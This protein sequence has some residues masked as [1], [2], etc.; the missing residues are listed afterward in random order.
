MSG[1]V[2]SDTERA[3]ALAVAV[4]EALEIA[5]IG[6]AI[7]GLDGVVL[8]TNGTLRRWAGT[9]RS[10]PGPA[11][12]LLPAGD[13]RRRLS[14]V[15]A[16][17]A[18]SFETSRCELVP[19]VRGSFSVRLSPLTVAGR[20]VACS[21]FVTD[22]Q[23]PVEAPDRP[24]HE[25]FRDLVDGAADG[26][27]VARGDVL[28]YANRAVRDWLGLPGPEDVV[29]RLLSEI[30]GVESPP[31]TPGQPG[32]IH[33]SHLRR[34]DGGELPVAVSVARVRLPE[35]ATTVL[36]LR[37][38]APPRAESGAFARTLELLEEA[39]GR[40][41][42]TLPAPSP[43]GAG[44]T[45][46]EASER[47]AVAL[48]LCRD[49]RSMASVPIVASAR[50][51]RAEEPA[52]DSR[53]LPRGRA[54]L[55]VVLVCDDEA[56]LAMLTAGLLEQHGYA[57]VT[58][59]TAGSAIEA[60]ATQRIDVMLLDL[61][62]PDGNAHE[63]IARMGEQSLQHPVILT[64]GYAEEDVDPTLLRGPLVVGY[65]AKPYSMD[66]LIAAIDR[67]LEQRTSAGVR[68]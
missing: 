68:A 20:I 4:C 64:S 23:A 15:A 12:G 37:R 28:L 9:D 13:I 61:H 45:S 47:L 40:A 67:A 36:V 49:L 29:G 42:E 38:R 63:V 66:R 8:A 24:M 17:E 18:V 55:G 2:T 33:D 60:L 19:A 25:R 58:V 30:F 14:R 1:T 46:D 65:L 31:G 41:K 11:A 21:V 26:V 57:A 35:G 22:E 50:A 39:L 51:E 53:H 59:G 3:Q 43:A 52:P 44:F 10:L 5:P 34:A 7:L 32:G 27:I 6:V 48:A 16:G 62:L 54:P 56:R